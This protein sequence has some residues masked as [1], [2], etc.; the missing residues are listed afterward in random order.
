MSGPPSRVLAFLP[1]LYPGQRDPVKPRR[2]GKE[3]V[4]VPWHALPAWIAWTRFN[5][6]GVRFR[7]ISPL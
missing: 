5:R 3:S 6:A 2:A 4:V 7:P 1:S